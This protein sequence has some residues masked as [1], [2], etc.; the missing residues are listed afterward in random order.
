MW[1]DPG[2]VNGG[3]WIITLR[4]SN[5][6]LLDRSWLWLAMALIGETLDDLDDVT[7]AVVSTRA[8]G[9]R[10]A[11]W[12][13]DKS[14]VNLVN[15]I[16]QR[17]VALLELEREP[18]VSLEFTANMLGDVG[19][20]SSGSLRSSLCQD[21]PSKYLAF[22]NPVASLPHG[23]GL[24]PHQ[25]G[26][27]RPHQPPQTSHMSNTSALQ[28]AQ[29]QSLHATLPGSPIQMHGTLGAHLRLHNSPSKGSA[30]S[31]SISSLVRSP[32]TSGAMGRRG[33]Q[34]PEAGS[35]SGLG[36]SIGFGGPIGRTNSPSP[37]PKALRGGVATG[38]ELGLM[39]RAK[40]GSS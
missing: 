8:K 20:S 39:N 35:I 17:L 2:N 1:E 31:N 14:D 29:Q 27:G 33:S 15:K 12:I 30:S 34:D 21:S 28:Q 32:S 38:P 25:K 26:F 22:S 37:A 5:P 36:F 10:I 11:L 23:V 9:D 4:T 3:K 19:N 6:A 40:V 13:R 7:G 24:T 16:G 18:G